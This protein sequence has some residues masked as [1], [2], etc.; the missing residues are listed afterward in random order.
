M[1]WGHNGDKRRIYFT[2]VEYMGEWNSKNIK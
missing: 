2:S 1:N